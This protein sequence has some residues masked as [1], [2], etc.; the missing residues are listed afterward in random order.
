MTHIPFVSGCFEVAS[1]VRAFS[2]AAKP[3]KAKDGEG[4]FFAE[5]GGSGGYKSIAQ[6]ALYECSR[7]VV[8]H[9]T[10]APRGIPAKINGIRSGT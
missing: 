1:K 5:G 9:R 10:C 8:G 7:F 4:G 3:V 6:A 2:S